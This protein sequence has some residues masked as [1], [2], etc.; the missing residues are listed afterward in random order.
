MADKETTPEWVSKLRTPELRAFE[1][2]FASNLTRARNLSGMHFELVFPSIMENWRLKIMT[3]VIKDG[4]IKKVMGNETFTPEFLAEVDKRMQDQEEE[5]VNFLSEGARRT[6]DRLSKQK[7]KFA[8]WL[9]ALDQASVMATWSAFETLSAD[10]WTFAV[11]SQPELFA[12]K[13]LKAFNEGAPEGMSGRSIPIG[14]A[15]KYK[16]DLRNCIG[17]IVAQRID[18]TLPS[19][20]RKA[21]AAAFGLTAAVEDMLRSTD[22]KQLLLARNLIAHRSGIIDSHYVERSGS[23]QTIGEELVVSTEDSARFI[24]IVQKIGTGLLAI[25]DDAI[26]PPAVQQALMLPSSSQEP[27]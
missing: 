12:T 18:F 1:E 7:P 6:L 21:Y 17:D 19:E 16:F 9:R 25:V 3:Q 13:V 15:A 10:V 11:N 5:V 20:I 26:N 23:T 4:V 2:F 14:I 8:E 24:E 27:D 22:L